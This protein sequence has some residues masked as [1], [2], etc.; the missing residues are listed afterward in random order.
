MIAAIA[1]S[2]CAGP[3]VKNPAPHSFL[4]ADP[5]DRA[6]YLIG[7]G[8]EIEIKFYYNPELNERLIVR[9][10]G[11][12]SLAFIQDIQAAGRT[13]AALGQDVQKLLAGHVKRADVVVT[14]RTFTSQRIF[15]GGEVSRPGPVQMVGR[16]SVLQGLTEAGWIRD[17]AR[18]EEV[19]LVRR[20]PSGGRQIF[21]INI[22]K[23]LNGEDMSQDVILKPEDMLFIPP[24]DIANFDRWVDQHIRQALFFSTNVGV[25]REIGPN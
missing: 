2:A 8:D 23:A 20:E 16:L 7:I 18:R 14:V 25:T 19:V 17:T 10:D 12:V 1:V 13:P 6:N 3:V 24:S 9:P 11:M 15:V 21:A 4:S 5:V 22:D